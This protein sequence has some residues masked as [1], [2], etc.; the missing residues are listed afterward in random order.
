[1]LKRSSIGLIRRYWSSISKISFRQ[2]LFP[3]WLRDNPPGKYNLEAIEIRIVS[4]RIGS[5]LATSMIGCDLLAAYIAVAV[6]AAWTNVHQNRWDPSLCDQVADVTQLFSL[7]VD[8]AHNVRL[9]RARRYFWLATHHS[10][11]PVWQPGLNKAWLFPGCVSG[12]YG[13]CRNSFSRKVPGRYSF[14]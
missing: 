3:D 4:S 13:P 11:L 5:A 14:L 2:R 1:M 7:G 6:L 8:C 9:E 10:L 12:R